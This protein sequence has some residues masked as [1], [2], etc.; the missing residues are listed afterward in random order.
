MNLT[1]IQIKL[2]MTLVLVALLQAWLVVG[3]RYLQI[4][5]LQRWIQ[6]DADMIRSH[7][8]FLLM[9]LLLLSFAPLDDRVP[10][11]LILCSLAGAVSNPLL[12]QI[13]AIRPQLSRAPFSPFGI[14]SALSFLTA[15]TGFGGRAALRLFL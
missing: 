15:T 5:P 6:S 4:T 11:W 3:R 1:E 10:P 7:V 2:A 13:L 14:F 12:F 9:A 8:D